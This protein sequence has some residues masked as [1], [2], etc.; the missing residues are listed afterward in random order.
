MQIQI[1]MEINT[2]AS[3]VLIAENEEDRIDLAK[4]PVGSLVRVVNSNGNGKT[5]DTL[6]FYPEKPVQR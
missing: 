5:V 2:G 3:F 4:I 1:T 6:Y